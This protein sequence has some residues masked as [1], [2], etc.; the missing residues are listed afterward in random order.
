MLTEN[1]ITEIFCICDYFCKVF[2]TKVA[3]NAI[4]S[5]KYR[6]YGNR[7]SAITEYEMMT[8]LIIIHSDSFR[9]FKIFYELYIRDKVRHL[10]PNAPSYSRFVTLMQM[11]GIKPAF[12][13]KM[14]LTG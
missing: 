4:N 10:F 6:G 3:T 7:T 12:F 13:L 8:T 9:N 1:K 5:K 2:D 11:V 14:Y